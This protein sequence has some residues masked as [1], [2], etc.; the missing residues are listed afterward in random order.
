[1]YIYNI[2]GPT[3]A[4]GMAFVHLTW[5]GIEAENSP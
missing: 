1:M 4:P 2:F 3:S 5:S